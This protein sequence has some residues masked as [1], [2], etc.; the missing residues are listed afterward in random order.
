MNWP[1]LSPECTHELA[2]ALSEACQLKPK[3]LFEHVAK[4]LQ[5]RATELSGVGPDDFRSHF[6]ECKRTARTYALEE[7]C[8]PEQDP[9]TWVPMRYN[10]ETIFQIL[11][12][13][14]LQII[15]DILSSEPVPDFGKLV[16]LAKAAL[17]ELAYLR[18]TAEEIT[19][20]QALRVVY[21]GLS[22]ACES[23]LDDSLEDADV[24][25]SFRCGPVLHLVRDICAP[26]RRREE[27]VEALII[28]S[29][30]RALG[31]SEVFRD[32]FGGG[33]A[34]PEMA[35]R[36]AIDTEPECLPSYQRLKE[37]SQ[38]LVLA[39]LQ[40]WFPIDMLVSAEA[41][42][43]HLAKVKD[44]LL[45]QDMG[46][47]F[48]M[49]S[50]AV[51]HAV[52]H[53]SS[54][55]ADE[56]VDLL[57][58]ASQTV[59]NVE[60]YAAPRAYEIY[61]KRRAERQSWRLAREDLQ[62]RATIRLCCAMGLEDGEAWSAMGE[63]FSALSEREREALKVELGRKDGIAEAPA[64]ILDG[65]DAFLAQAYQNDE[66]ALESAVKLLARI[67]EDASRNFDKSL[68][69]KVVRLCLVG[70]P[71][72]ARSFRMEGIHFE[73][74]AFTLEETGPGEVH[75]RVAGC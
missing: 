28:V 64:Y 29:L 42:P 56:S 16:P 75:V 57:R 50:L 43:A 3:D 41:V 59:G 10:D 74:L 60:K 18:G 25:Y 36:N 63:A 70:L 68:K 17:P 19:A 49:A 51:D 62:Q 4:K 48:F 24:M 9:L 13:S 20:L 53:R 14:A 34:S 47:E 67:L 72:R 2:T 31:A 21:L 12:S 35:M 54:T 69:H 66:I 71:A 1:G 58:L 37:R 5:D 39:A 23:G 27:L 7:F 45:P 40:A 11:R 55:V 44:L 26:L 22:G 15:A 38:E 32:R 61:L 8:P 30:F 73:D 6:E 33:A 46:V 52:R 65:S